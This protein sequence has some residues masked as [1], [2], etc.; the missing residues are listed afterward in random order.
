LAQA[1]QDGLSGDAPGYVAHL[2][3]GVENTFIPVPAAFSFHF[4]P[5][6][7][8]G[9]ANQLGFFDAFKIQFDRESFIS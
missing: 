1:S 3:I 5:D 2:E 8:G 7:F 4:P 6:E 9:P